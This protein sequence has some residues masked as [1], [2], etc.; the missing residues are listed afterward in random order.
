MKTNIRMGFSTLLLF[1][2]LN[3][4]TASARD[5]VSSSDKKFLTNAAQGG[6]AEVQES[7]A[8]AGRAENGKVNHFARH[9]IKDHSQANQKLMSLADSKGVTLPSSPSMMQMHMRNKLTKLQGAELDRAYMAQSVKDH[10]STISLFEGAAQNAKD[11]QIRRFAA[12]TLPTLRHHL[13][14]ARDI[15]N[16]VAHE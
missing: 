8:V 11:P 16:Q 9:M 15:N 5:D 13:K 12:D 14:M 7:E 10:E 4:S 6:M 1:A 3:T 2:F